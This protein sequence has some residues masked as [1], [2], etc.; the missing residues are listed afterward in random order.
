MSVLIKDVTR[1]YKGKNTNILLKLR[2][3]RLTVIVLQQS[4]AEHTFIDADA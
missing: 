1:N 2:S 4:D 3:T